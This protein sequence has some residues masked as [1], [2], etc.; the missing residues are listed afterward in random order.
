M[1]NTIEKLK[2]LLLSI[3][4][5][6]HLK[7][8]LKK[9]ILLLINPIDGARYIEFTY[10]LKFLKEK[11]INLTNKKILDISSPFLM[12]YLLSYKYTT[13]ILKTDLNPKEQFNISKNPNIKFQVENAHKLSFDNNIFDFTYSISV[14]EH[15]YKKYDKALEELIR[16]TRPS[17]LIYISLPI[18]KYYSEEFTKENSYGNQSKINEQYFF[19]YIFDEEKINYLLNKFS[20]KIAILDKSYFFDKGLND[21]NHLVRI[22]KYTSPS[23]YINVLKNSII[24][25]YYGFICLKGKNINFCESKNFGIACILLQKR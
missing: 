21:Y 8:T 14:L 1:I 11:N 5:I 7:I 15:I 23:H 2:L 12:A 25:L 10:C 20:K 6:L 16:V 19:Q 9:K 18:S 13:K 17:G 22:I 24:N 3:K 4:V